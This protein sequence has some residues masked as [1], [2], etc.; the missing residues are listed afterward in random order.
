MLQLNDEKHAFLAL[1]RQRRGDTKTYRKAI[2]QF[3]PLQMLEFLGGTYDKQLSI[4]RREAPRNNLM[5]AGWCGFGLVAGAARL[6]YTA[7]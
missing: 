7:T 5:P 4:M 6:V 1:I 2:G 3:P